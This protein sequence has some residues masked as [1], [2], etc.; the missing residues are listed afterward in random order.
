MLDDNFR[1][2]RTI[3]YGFSVKLYEINS[4]LFFVCISKLTI[5]WAPVKMGRSWP[6]YNIFSYFQFVGCYVRGRFKSNSGFVD[7]YT[8]SHQDFIRPLVDIAGL[9]IEQK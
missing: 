6:W 1:I 3:E 4:F 8:E 5:M 2:D 7:V 9:V